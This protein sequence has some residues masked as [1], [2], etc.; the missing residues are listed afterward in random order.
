MW[1]AVKLYA[2]TTVIFLAIDLSYL[3]LIMPKF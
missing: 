1:H 3:G 2:L